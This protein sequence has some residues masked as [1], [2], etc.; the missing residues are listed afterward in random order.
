[1]GQAETSVE[2][3]AA[4][5]RIIR[6]TTVAPVVQRHVAPEALAAAAAFTVG[7]AAVPR[8]V[9]SVLFA[10]RTNGMHLDVDAVQQWP[11]TRRATGVYFV[12]HVG[13]EARSGAKVR[14]HVSTVLR[15][16]DSS[17]LLVEMSTLSRLREAIDGSTNLYF[18][19]GD[20]VGPLYNRA[21]S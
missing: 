8:N 18:F 17:F 15:W 11:E 4:A 6:A 14:M 13:R 5:E 16:S 1:V 9:I 3:A 20:C 19:T 10:G 21:K 7:V 12:V 2:Q